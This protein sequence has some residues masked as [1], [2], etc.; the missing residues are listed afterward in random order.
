MHGLSFRGEGIQDLVVDEGITEYFT[1][2]I[3]MKMGKNLDEYLTLYSFASTKDDKNNAKKFGPY[4]YITRFM[5]HMLEDK[6][7]GK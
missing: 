5:K 4:E 7:A 3:L 2:L 1:R 6:G